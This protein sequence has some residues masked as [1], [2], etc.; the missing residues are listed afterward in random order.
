MEKKFE[1]MDVLPKP[2]YWGGWRV[3]PIAIEFWYSKDFYFNRKC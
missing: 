1:K 3:K 2:D